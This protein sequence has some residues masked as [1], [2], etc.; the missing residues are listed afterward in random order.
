MPHDKN[1]KV[2]NIG[3]KVMIE[4]VVTQ[5]NMGEEFC[6]A[7]METVEPMYPGTYKTVIT[8]NAKQVV[9]Q[10]PNDDGQFL[11]SGC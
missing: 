11:M 1:N 9:K 8:L 5:V 6:N 3:D 4:A 10:E 7:T 2:L